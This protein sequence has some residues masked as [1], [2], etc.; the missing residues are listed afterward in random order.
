MPK[1][2][3]QRRVYFKSNIIEPKNWDSS[4]VTLP[5]I[6]KLSI[7]S[8]EFKKDKPCI[9]D[10]ASVY[11]TGSFYIIGGR[12]EGMTIQTYD[13]IYRLEE[14]NWKWS[15]AGKLNTRR[16]KHGALLAHKGCRN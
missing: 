12:D 2:S 3:H 8:I 4:R 14:N 11:T 5:I 7:K 16:A 9:F 1:D 15:K 6:D 10:Y 13:T